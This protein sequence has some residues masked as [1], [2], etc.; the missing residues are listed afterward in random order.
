MNNQEERLNQIQ[1]KIDNL[2][3]D[4]KPKFP[5]LRIEV[6]EDKTYLDGK[7]IEVTPSISKPESIDD[8]IQ[9][10]ISEEKANDSYPSWYGHYSFE[11]W[12][13]SVNY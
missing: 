1:A 10:T 7:L 12:H 6:I 2:T 4:L 3:S 8:K 9:N 11:F 5:K 13:Y